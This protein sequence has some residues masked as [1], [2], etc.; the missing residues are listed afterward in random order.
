M[1]PTNAKLKARAAAM[2]AELAGVSE[3]AAAAALDRSG[4]DVGMAVL[5]ARGFALDDAK[6][7]LARHGGALAPALAELGG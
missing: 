3:S 6:A 5:L 7:L 2:V 4:H 1:R